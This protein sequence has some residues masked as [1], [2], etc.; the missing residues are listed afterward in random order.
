[1]LGHIFKLLKPL[2]AQ[3]LRLDIRALSVK[4]V[5]VAITLLI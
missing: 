3:L 5:N 1:M 2:R 4:P